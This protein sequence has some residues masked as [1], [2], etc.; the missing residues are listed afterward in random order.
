MV[1][2]GEQCVIS[3]CVFVSRPCIDMVH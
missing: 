3:Q 1:Y 2:Q